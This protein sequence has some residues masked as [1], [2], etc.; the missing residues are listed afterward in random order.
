M[1]RE[2]PIGVTLVAA[3]QAIN[4]VATGLEVLAGKRAVPADDTTILAIVGA[5]I[6]LGG[7]V[8]AFAL[9]RLHPWAWTATMIW[10]GVVMGLALLAYVQG[11]PSYLVMALSVM[12]VFYLNQ[13]DVQRV[14]G[15]TREEAS[16]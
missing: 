3:V 2:R 8:V 10:V 1:R 7:L 5:A 12:Q 16:P 14:F 9:W 6:A 13:S 15:R 4:A 11:R